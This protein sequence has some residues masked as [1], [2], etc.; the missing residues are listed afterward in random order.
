MQLLDIFS[1]GISVDKVKPKVNQL[2]CCLPDVSAPNLDYDNLFRIIIMNFM[3]AHDFDVR[4]VKKSCVHIVN[5]DL[6]MMRR[7]S[8]GSQATLWWWAGQG[9]GREPQGL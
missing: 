3:D 2:L 8:Q 1:T 9:R 5:K 4:A 6:K 7:V